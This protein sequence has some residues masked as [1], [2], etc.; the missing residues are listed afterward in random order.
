MHVCQIWVNFLNKEKILKVPEKRIFPFH[1]K[2]HPSQHADHQIHYRTFGKTL[3]CKWSQMNKKIII[4]EISKQETKH[5]WYVLFFFCG[6]L[7][8][9]IKF[10]CKYFCTGRRQHVQD[11]SFQCP[12]EVVLTRNAVYCMLLTTLA[13]KQWCQQRKLHATPV[14]IKP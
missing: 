12:W 1:S 2:L 5:Y 3:S 9:L 13:H 14:L 4:T 10:T 11:K 7:I 8:H 6:L